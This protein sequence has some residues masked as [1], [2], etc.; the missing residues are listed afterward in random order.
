MPAAELVLLRVLDAAD[1]AAFSAL[2]LEALENEP[3]SFSATPDE[4]RSLSAAELQRRVQPVPDGSFLMGAFQDGRLIGTAGLYRDPVA[5]RNHKA[6]LW[7][8]Y[9]TPA[10]RGRGLAR[11]LVAAVLQR[12]RGYPDL[13]K[14]VLTVS[15]PPA[16]ALYESL[17]FRTFGHERIALVVNGVPVDEDH[18]E[19]LLRPTE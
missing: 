2:R 5:K 19:L 8:V 12:A 10:A 18:M 16:R 6:V 14:V 15:S 1:A 4:H 11:N 13:Q 9:V 17:G 7:G 3:A